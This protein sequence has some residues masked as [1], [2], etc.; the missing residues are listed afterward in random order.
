MSAE[1]PPPERTDTSHVEY[2]D[3]SR[4]KEHVWYETRDHMPGVK[5]ENTAEGV[6]YP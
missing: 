1:T 5:G 4:G 3:I 6:Y 2:I